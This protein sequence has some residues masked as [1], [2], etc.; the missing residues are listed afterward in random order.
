MWRGKTVAVILPTYR[1]KDSI[2]KCINDLEALGIVDKIIVVNNNASLGTS[3][4]VAK[5]TAVEIFEPIQGYGAAIQCGFRY[6]AADLI[7]VIEPADTLVMNDVY[8]FLA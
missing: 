3:E 6:A 2:R 4:E 7:F 5:T 8:K 1:E